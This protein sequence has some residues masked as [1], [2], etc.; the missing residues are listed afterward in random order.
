MHH[1]TGNL[2]EQLLDATI[3]GRIEWAEIAGTTAYDY[4]AG[5]FT[6][7]IDA[8]DDHAS[9]LLTDADGNALEAAQSDALA[10]IILNNGSTALSSVKDIHAIAVRTASGT[11]TAIAAVIAHIQGLGHENTISAE[12]M[13]SQTDAPDTSNYAVEHNDQHVNQ[14]EDTEAE[15]AA[16]TEAEAEIEEVGPEESGPYEEAQISE[17]SAPLEEST[18]P[19]QKKK[20]GGFSLF[21][22]KKR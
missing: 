9:F 17:Q 6:V 18:A 21:G 8:G 22:K 11:E 20:R 16:Y 15:N 10:A 2:L 12:D 19:S 7:K 13:T 3:N 1:N 14:G 5:D 4:R